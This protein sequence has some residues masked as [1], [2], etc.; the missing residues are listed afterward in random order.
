MIA[1]AMIARST[2]YTIRG[3]DTVQVMETAKSLSRLGVTV[4]IKLTNEA[5]D[6]TRYD[7]LHFF[8]IIR[9]ADILFH[10]KRSRKPFVLSPVLVDYSE[11]DKY[12][13]AGFSGRLFRLFSAER[14]EYIKAVGKWLLGK[15]RLMS[16][17]YLWKGQRRSI[18]KVLANA[19]MLLP[20]SVSE[21][22]RLSKQYPV[23]CAHT[24]VVNGI[25]GGVFSFDPAADKDPCL[26]I[27]A[28][29]IEG[30]KNQLNLV[31]AMNNTPYTLLIIGAPAPNHLD[32][33]S[34]CK[35]I[36]AGNIRF[37]EHISQEELRNYYQR[38]TVHVLPSWFETTGLSSLEAGSMGCNLVITDKGDARSY[39]GEQAFYC[40][41]SSPE[42]IFNA[43]KLAAE[44][45]FDG[46]LR[47]KIVRQYTW[48][49]AALQTL[50]AYQKINAGIC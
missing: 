5:I 37:I 45:P 22:G 33:Y 43:V 34:E 39:F 19:S 27:C 28:A 49:Q 29:R 12:H 2:L 21:Y 25:D 8:N 38:A 1:V 44:K 36:A 40:D 35:H 23:S 20:N 15:D 7:L 11:F 9:P 46:L 48:Q 6:Y 16:P 10:V 13:R 4:D 50:S 17:S 14:I 42:S 32:Y 26:V 3:G 18:E 30:I 47:E 31:K 41:P 24:V